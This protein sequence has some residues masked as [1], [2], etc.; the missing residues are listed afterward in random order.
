MNSVWFYSEHPATS[1]RSFESPLS[2]YR[3]SR[4][5]TSIEA[6]IWLA[7]S[8][9]VHAR[10]SFLACVEQLGSGPDPVSAAFRRLISLLLQCM[11]PLSTNQ[12]IPKPQGDEWPASNTAIPPSTT[13]VPAN[14]W[15][16]TA[17]PTS[18]G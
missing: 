15:V 10:G 11:I 18:S 8:R 13:S 9:F 16:K 6:A 1:I 5:S 7:R 2:E 17:M 3:Q 4:E 12:K 14:C